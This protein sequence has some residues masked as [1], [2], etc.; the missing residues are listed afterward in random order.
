MSSEADEVVSEPSGLNPYSNGTMYLITLKKIASVDLFTG[1][2][3]YS[4]G[5]MYLICGE[6]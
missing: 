2:N 3:P 4:N 1:L 5:T 6:K